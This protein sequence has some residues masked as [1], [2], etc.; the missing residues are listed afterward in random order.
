[1]H[2]LAAKSCNWHCSI[3]VELP[4]VPLGLLSHCRGFTGMSKYVTLPKYFYV[5]PSMVLSLTYHCSLA[6]PHS[7]MKRVWL[8]KTIVMELSS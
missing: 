1:M 7:H 4:S 2:K 6:K 8:R 5:Y 3:Q